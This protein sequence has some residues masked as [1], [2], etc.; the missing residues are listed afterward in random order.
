MAI[1]NLFLIIALLSTA[2]A[3]QSQPT[4][5]NNLSL[6]GFTQWNTGRDK[7]TE[8]I[9]PAGTENGLTIE[10]KKTVAHVR[11]KVKQYGE[12]SFPI[13]PATPAG[14][15]ALAVNLNKS[16]FIKLRYKA[17]NE[18]VLQLRQTGVHGG[19]Q[20]HVVLPPSK[21][22]ITRKI[23]FSSFTG[24]LKPLDLKDVAKF[25]FAFLGN[26]PVDGFADLMIASFKIDHYK[27]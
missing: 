23:Y 7:L 11:F 3:V 1:K 26:N 15:E 4:A 9:I 12:L 21:K 18:V 10:D 25:N 19:V 20:N 14:T 24:G 6:N 22:F 27:P 13:N 5:G 2:S 16:K 8:Q 17:N